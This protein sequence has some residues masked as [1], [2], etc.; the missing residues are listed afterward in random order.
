MDAE[1]EAAALRERYG[2]RQ[3]IAE[4]SAIPQ[5]LLLP[6]VEDPSIWAVRCKPGKENE[7][8]ALL[9][10]AY[11]KLRKLPER[12]EI[13]SAFARGGT[14]AGYV[15]VEA[16]RQE[17]VLKAAD[18]VSLLY[19]RAARGASAHKLIP[20][21]EM[22]DLLRVRK[23]KQLERGMWVRMKKPAKYAGDLGQ[24]DSVDLNGTDITVKLIP[25]IDYGHDEDLNGPT[26][27]VKRKRA[28]ANRP[29]QRFFN[30]T[31]ARKKFGKSLLPVQNLMYKQFSFQGDSYIEGYV[32]KETNVFSIE[33]ENV[34]P[35]L[36]EIL[37]F[38]TGGEDGADTLDIASLAATYKNDMSGTDFQ[39]ED[40]VE[41]Y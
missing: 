2:R 7:A 8:A 9:Y 23:A 13:F 10:K 35:T 11:N 36:D 12:F 41:I 27:A 19:P 26:G 22:A 5:H 37:F 38:R 4:V 29:P 25:R 30:E 31:E 32:F 21:S 6:S 1:R 17:E 28:G 20:I 40:A 18:R 24:I 14:M 34:N 15:Y 33:T 39:A 3:R 16:R